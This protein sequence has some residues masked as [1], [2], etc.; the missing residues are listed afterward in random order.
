MKKLSF[1]LALIFLSINVFAQKKW[2]PGVKGYASQGYYKS[3]SEGARVKTRGGSF[4]PS[5]YSL[6]EYAPPVGEQEGGTCVGWATA[7]AGLSILENIK[8]D[9]RDDS[10]KAV[11]AFSPYFT[12]ILSK[13]DEDNECLIL[14]R[15]W[16]P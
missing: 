2:L 1:I 6:R 5:S 12:Y 10:L 4:L 15:M 9:R 14:Y 11:N 3:E 7:Y 13:F 16:V 8:L